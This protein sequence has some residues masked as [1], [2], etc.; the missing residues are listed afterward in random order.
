[1]SILTKGL[2]PWCSLPFRFLAHTRPRPLEQVGRFALSRTFSSPIFPPSPPDHIR[3]DTDAPPPSFLEEVDEEY[4]YS[5]P[6]SSFATILEP[7]GVNETI[8]VSNLL[9]RGERAKASTVR[10]EFEEL[11]IQ[12]HPHR[13]FGDTAIAALNSHNAELGSTEFLEWW[14]YADIGRFPDAFFRA[15]QKLMTRPFDLTLLMSTC[16]MTAK[17]G[18]SELLRKSQLLPYV[19]Y[20]GDPNSTTTFL[21]RLDQE[22]SAHQSSGQPSTGWVWEVAVSEHASSG[23]LAIAKQLATYCSQRHKYNV[24][25]FIQEIQPSSSI[26]QQTLNSLD[27]TDRSRSRSALAREFRLIRYALREPTVSP[28]FYAIIARFLIGYG[29]EN[30]GRNLPRLLRLLRRRV[31]DRCS[32]NIKKA[33]IAAEMQMHYELKRPLAVLRTLLYSCIVDGHMASEARTI[34]KIWRDPRAHRR[35]WK[36]DWP[37]LRVSSTTLGQKIWPSET[38]LSLGWKALLM[39]ADKPRNV[40]HL[41]SIFLTLAKTSLSQPS[42]ITQ[43]L[44]PAPSAEAIE[45]HLSLSN[46]EG[47][48]SACATYPPSVFP[49]PRQLH[50]FVVAISSQTSP[51]RGAEVIQEMQSLGL[52]PGP[53]SW[54]AVAGAYARAGDVSRALR[55]LEHLETICPPLS[56]SYIQWRS[57]DAI[58]GRKKEKF[59][60][61]TVYAPSSPLLT[62]YNSCIRGLSEAGLFHEA[63]SVESLMRSK[64]LIT[65][66]FQDPYTKRVLARLRFYEQGGGRDWLKREKRRFFVIDGRRIYIDLKRTEWVQERGAEIESYRK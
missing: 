51:R 14:P 6:S 42:M 52:T 28:S 5:E 34:L 27:Q 46:S 33:F 65:P 4:G 10:R 50:A 49:T 61:R 66:T 3:P 2:T 1:M 48:V 8:I 47:S 29:C 54:G 22:L 17:A 40:E 39:L 31:F 60:G 43:E 58:Q 18:H 21:L 64:D 20:Y 11:G 44:L 26:S 53:Q 35:R 55:V 59:R 24:A 12:L 37:L 62:A 25:G 30:K 36:L 7:A 9:K 16:L 15:E 19:L 23:R 32:P 56:S 13:M 63:R 41:Y 45:R 57:Q 38:H